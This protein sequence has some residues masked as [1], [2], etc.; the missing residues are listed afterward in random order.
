VSARLLLALIVGNTNEGV[1]QPVGINSVAITHIL[2][3]S[4]SIPANATS[5]QP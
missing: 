3:R 5:L 1:Y 4:P 2:G